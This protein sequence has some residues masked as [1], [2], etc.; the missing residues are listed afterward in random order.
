MKRTLWL[1]SASL[2]AVFLAA[3]GRTAATPT[4]SP[5]PPS[6]ATPEATPVPAEDHLQ[7]IQSAG[8]IVVGTSA[9]YAPFEYYDEDFKMAG[10]DIELMQAI[11]EKLGVTAEFKDFAFE[12]LYDA[13][14]QGH[15]DASISAISVD[16]RREEFVAF[17]NIYYVSEDAF[18][19]QAAS[20]LSI[21]GL[22]DIASQ[23]VGVQAGT[24]YDNWIQ[25]N[26]VDTGLMPQRRVFVYR[27]VD[28][29]IRDLANGRIDVVIL[30]KPVAEKAAQDG[31]LKIAVSGLNRQLYGIAMPLKSAGL[32]VQ[33]NKALA[34]LQNDG[35]IAALANKYQ[36]LDPDEI[37]PL[38]TPEPVTPTPAAPTATPQAPAA[39]TD[40]MA[41]VTDLNYDDKNMTAPPV[42]RPGQAFT[43]SWRINN[44]GTCTWDSTYRLTY[45][46]GNTPAAQMGGQPTP[47]QGT[48]APGANYDMSVNLVAPIQPGV[49]QGFWQMVNGQGTP[50]GQRIY[51][52]ITVPAQATATP[53]ATPT[54]STDI[55]FTVNTTNISA[56]QCVTFSWSVQNASAVYFYALGQPWQQNGVP[57]VS[58]SVQCPPVTTTYELRVIKPSGETV[59]NQITINV[60]AAP[61]APQITRFTVVP[62][63]QITLGQ[64]LDIQWEVQ[65]S[66]ASVVIQRNNGDL[67]I[68]APL[69]G[70]LADCPASTGSFVYSV[71]AT[72]PGG[73]SRAQKTINVVSAATATPAPT[74]APEA[75]VITMFNVS[76][77]QVE[78]GQCVTGQWSVGGGANRA[79]FLKNGAVIYDNVPFVG[80]GQDCETAPGQVI[81]RLEA[82]N[83][84]GQMVSQERAVTVTDVTP[85][86][87][88]AGTFWRLDSFVQGGS[89]SP[90][91]PGTQITA[92]FGASGDL[93]GTSGCNNYSATYFVDGQGLRVANIAGSNML[94]SDPEG[95]ME[96]EGLY[97]QSLNNVATYRIEGSQLKLS[98]GGGQL[99][100]VYNR[101]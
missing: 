8:K 15:F 34:E 92:Q 17:S 36:G 14:E 61:T 49:Y 10:F 21:T 100:L 93:N 75:P 99:I 5:I 35:T 71:Q 78:T 37:V 18:L 82:Y 95:V 54:P 72:G 65:G 89:P 19:V 41:W 57:G 67:W 50:F 28:D 59:L 11:A 97:L 87:P 43:K 85:Q 13:L 24:V 94:C 80:T 25:E 42:M 79:R 16:T 31:V 48:V 91:L 20:D 83:A 55:S 12:G 84:A 32:Q 60:A 47:V 46:Q 40:G 62:E 88:L 68:N 9:D 23:R 64:C 27:Q 96:Q 3:C 22:R 2:L 4:A 1:L 26:L 81:Y 77:S 38:P 70:N 86:N 63:N 74:P 53:A 29:A 76:P 58:Q 90:V 52:G 51:V 66:V 98:D 101:Q 44:T 30:D 6:S 45:V 33:I 56:G 7:R 39:C 73:V 69:R